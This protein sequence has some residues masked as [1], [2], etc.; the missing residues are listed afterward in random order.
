MSEYIE[1]LNQTRMLDLNWQ[2]SQLAIDL[3]T[4]GARC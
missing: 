4:N 1:K 2:Q 3:I